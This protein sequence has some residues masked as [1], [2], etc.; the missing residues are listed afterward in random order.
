MYAECQRLICEEGGAIIPMFIDHIE[1]GT[2]RVQGWKPSAIFE[3][4]GLRIGE[5]VWLSS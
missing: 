2:T 5:K 1:A 4:M 3:L